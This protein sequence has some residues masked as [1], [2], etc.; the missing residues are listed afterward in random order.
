MMR[1]FQIKSVRI[2]A[3]LMPLFAAAAQQ[4][5]PARLDELE[6]LIQEHE[7]LLQ[8][9]PENEFTPVTKF[10]LARL[11]YDRSQ[12]LFQQQM[13][14]YERRDSRETE[15]EAAPL[16]PDMSRTIAL[17]RELLGKYPRIAFR[18]QVIYQLATAC[19]E[20]GEEE[21]AAHWFEL[22]AEEGA[23]PH[24]PEALFRLGEFAFDRRRFD[25]AALYYQKLL[26]L[27][28]TS[29]R[30]MALYKLGWSFFNLRRWKDAAQSFLTLLEQTAAGSAEEAADLNREAVHYLADSFIEAGGTAAA[31]AALSAHLD[32]SYVPQTLEKMAQLYEQR[33]LYQQAVEVYR[34][35]VRFYPSSPALPRYYRSMIEDWGAAGD[36]VE[37]NRVREEAVEKFAPGNGWNAARPEIAALG[38]ELCREVLIYLGKFHQAQGNEM[39][40]PESYRRA[41]Y[42]YD[43]F[44]RLFPQDSLR[45]EIY[46]LQAESLFALGEYAA[47][48]E[49]YRAAAAV[50]L[51][52]WR[53]KAAYNRVL[54]RLKLRSTEEPDTLRL[55]NFLNSEAAIVLPN[56]PRS[57]AELLLA[58]NEFYCLFPQSEWL[59][60]VLMIFGQVLYENGALI[61]AV[62]TYERILKLSPTGPLRAAAAANIA[63]AFFDSCNYREAQRWF[64][65][66]AKLTEEPEEARQFKRSAVSAQFKLAEKMSEQGRALE[67]AHILQQASLAGV[68]SRMEAQA[69]FDAALQLQRADSLLQAA[70]L[71]EQ[72]VLRFPDAE[73]AAAALFQAGILR[74]QLG[75]WALAAANF[76][77]TAESYPQTP[78]RRQALKNAVRCYEAAEDWL[79]VKAASQKFVQLYADSTES[80]EYLYRVGEA[81]Q[82]LGQPQEAER[83]FRQVLQRF[84]EFQRR[85][86]DVD[87]YFVAA[88][89]FMLAEEQFAAFKALSLKPPFEA[90]L[91][92][93]MTAFNSVL[94][95]FSDAARYRS[96]D[97]TTA[98]MFRIGET[99]EEM[100]HAL[101]Q[102]PLPDGLSPEEQSLYRQ[103][104]AEHS[105]PFIQR[106]LEAHQ[107]NLTQAAVNGIENQ[108]V[109]MSREHAARL[110]SVLPPNVEDVSAV[111]EER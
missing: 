83:E 11:Y 58:C 48:A 51:S 44:L 79:A 105:L 3:F 9:Y 37:A 23:T 85:G 68:D 40:S 94:Q 98:A 18:D 52:P 96:A 66:A 65:A 90:N 97:W 46:Y 67:A 39:Q 42:E 16:R 26:D 14:A 110:Q 41:V 87:P 107:S 12:L 54:S 34:L 38:T 8:K 13:A 86:R 63:R 60:R 93:K 73:Q 74:E 15:S 53:E 28:A 75:D 104:L 31:E 69:L 92:K 72:L 70:R 56:L 102:A 4:A 49:A 22:L 64:V 57:D 43:R 32:R 35:L 103:K 47:A 36:A 100:V 55:L 108:W 6:R 30:R 20:A 24:L 21:E 10:Q 80:L 111:S 59:D 27:G 29:F 101:E 50:P 2:W 82:R 99:F 62:K 71:F 78:L 77:R 89:Q 7:A 76:R 81:S 25:Q 33:S 88:A 17:C 95:A 106:A 45:G 19:Q 84:T 91:K 61:S 109:A 5:P 1:W